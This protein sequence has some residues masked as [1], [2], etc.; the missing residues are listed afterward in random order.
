MVAGTTDSQERLP[1]VARAAF[2]FR[3]TVRDNRAGGGAV[4]NGDVTLAVS[5]TAGARLDLISF[6]AKGGVA[7]VGGHVEMNMGNQLRLHQSGMNAVAAVTAFRQKPIYITE[8]DPDGCAAC[9][10]SMTPAD[11]YRNSPAYGAYEVAMMKR[12]LELETRVGERGVHECDIGH[13]RGEQTN[14]P[15][16]RRHRGERFVL[17]HRRARDRTR[18]D[19]RQTARCGFE[20][21]RERKKRPVFDLNLARFVRLREPTVGGEVGER[22]S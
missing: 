1:Q 2:R 9:P 5:G 14:G 18:H 4:N 12:T 17:L 3:C 22:V 6:H 20:A 19:R 15:V 21:L 13:K 10:V 8:A 11:A 16:G 7:M